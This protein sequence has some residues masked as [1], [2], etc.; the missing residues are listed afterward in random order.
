MTRSSL[1]VGD[2]ALAAA[3]VKTSLDGLAV[4]DRE[5]RHV[6]WNSARSGLPA[7]PRPR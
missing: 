4:L 7:S 6:L 5:L 1:D 3:V 2:T